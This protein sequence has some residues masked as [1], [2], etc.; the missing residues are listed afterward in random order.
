MHLGMKG[1]R[2]TTND[3]HYGPFIGIERA[4]LELLNAPWGLTDCACRKHIGRP[5]LSALRGLALKR[6]FNR[7][8][9]YRN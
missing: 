2:L 4:D 6:A 9:S 3:P 8:A 7:V 1:A 5:W